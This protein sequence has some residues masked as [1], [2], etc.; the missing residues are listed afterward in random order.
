LNRRFFDLENEL[1][2]HQ[3]ETSVLD[4]PISVFRPFLEPPNNGKVTG[5]VDRKE[6]V[7]KSE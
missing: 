5:L 2:N 6:K 4:P 1:T 3:F 7:Q